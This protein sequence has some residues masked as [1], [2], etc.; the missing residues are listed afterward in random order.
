MPADPEL[1]PRDPFP[2]L[3]GMD[4]QALEDALTEQAEGLRPE[5]SIPEI[6]WIMGWGPWGAE[7]TKNRTNNRFVRLR[8]KRARSRRRG[9]V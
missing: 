9:G 5:C 8:K 6:G 3:L 4:G 2:L 1:H 7:E